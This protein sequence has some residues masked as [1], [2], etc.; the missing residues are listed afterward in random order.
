MYITGCYVT[1]PDQFEDENLTAGIF[2]KI[3]GYFKKITEK[4]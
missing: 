2:M 3:S 4:T 1:L